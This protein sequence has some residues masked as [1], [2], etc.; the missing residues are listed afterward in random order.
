MSLAKYFSKDLLAIRQVLGHGSLEKFEQ[1]LNSHVIEIA[2]DDEVNKS[3]GGMMLDILV[4]LLSRLYP[5]MKFTYLGKGDMSAVIEDCLKKVKSINSLVEVEESKPS[6]SIIIGKTE[7]GSDGRRMYV[8]SD[9]WTAKLSTNASLVCGESFNPFGAGVAGCLAASNLFRFIF[10]EFINHPELDSNVS[11]DVSSLNCG[12]PADVDVSG[13]DLGVI[14]LAGMGAIGNG[15][16]WAM[17]NLVK[18]KGILKVIDHETLATSNLQ[19]YIATKENDVG[20]FKSDLAK[21]FYSGNSIVVEPFKMK[22]AEYISTAEGSSVELVAVA[23]DSAKDR[24]GIQSSL[25]R[26]IINAFTENNIAGITRH[27]NFGDKAC[28]VCGFIPE[29]KMRDYSQEVSDNLGISNLENQVRHYI[30]NNS[31]VDDNLITW[32][33]NANGIRKEDLS[34]FIGQPFSNFYSDAVCGGMLLSLTGTI[35]DN[36][37]MEAPLAF[38]SAIAGILLASEVVLIKCGYRNEEFP[39]S[40]QLYPLLKIKSPSNPYS[41]QLL[42]DSTTR[43]ICADQDFKEVYK[44]KW[45]K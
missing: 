2:F 31:I 13:I 28:L 32:I 34:R 11:L 33:S 42:R 15:F 40:S 5:R 24:I 1:L 21:D 36:F 20:K 35:S 3:E 45:R 27:L 9:K 12:T 17:S 7:T 23:V 8:G 26:L 4:R 43:C 10:Q 22:W 14:H 39:N 37:K 29:K 44:R 19:R 30:A 16:L 41:T 25:P 18:C 38:Q 6:F